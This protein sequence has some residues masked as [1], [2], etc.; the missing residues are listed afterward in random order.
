MAWM[1]IFMVYMV[2]KVM[3]LNQITTMTGWKR[4]RANALNG[5]K[6][7]INILAKMLV[8]FCSSVCRFGSRFA[9]VSGKHR[10]TNI[11]I[12]PPKMVRNQRYFASRDPELKHH[13]SS[14]PDRA[15]REGP[16]GRLP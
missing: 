12:T 11:S 2:K 4:S 14:A 3:T 15:R 16:V 13:R 7:D 8:F 9:I 1:E 5:P 6:M 10:K